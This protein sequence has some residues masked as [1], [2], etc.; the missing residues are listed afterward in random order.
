[1][2]RAGDVPRL[3]GALA[4]LLREEGVSW[5]SIGATPG[6]F[7][8]ACVKED[9]SGVI[10]QRLN[11]LDTAGGWPEDLRRDLAQR[12]HAEAARELL[13]AREIVSALDAL[14][15]DGIYPILLKGTS[16]A[17]SAYDM[18]SWR[19]RADTDL[20]IRREE[21][22]A[23]RR[24]MATLG[25]SAPNQCDGE[26]LFCQFEM[27]KDDGFGVSHAFDFHWKIS[28]QSVFADLL[29][30]D[31]LAAGAVRIPALGPCARGAGPEHALLL[32]CIHPAMH[33]RN[34]ERLIWLHDVHL[35]VSRLS[36]A[37]L[38]G[39]AS[40]AIRKRVAAVCAHQL[41]LAHQRLGTA[42]PDAVTAKLAVR[43]APEPS[44]IYLEPGR[45][46]HD[47]LVSSVRGLPRWK[48]RWHLLREVILPSPGFMLRSYGLG[49]GT[50]AVL[51]PVLYVHRGLRGAWKVIAGRK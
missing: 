42:V 22:D 7:V 34:V 23:V 1:V 29:T 5:S 37:E 46:W 48:D 10:S 35:L 36:D 8:D 28:T 50:A 18:P 24:V 27:Q 45:R 47:E 4:A 38:D 20:F 14:A 3:A 12:A 2:K 41:A 25:Y 21:I 16:L 39:F 15:A 13:R 44:A 51:L 40:L 32:A 33:H 9:L 26:H 19:P 49:S 31:E 6:E 43:D 17:Y 11:R 30:F